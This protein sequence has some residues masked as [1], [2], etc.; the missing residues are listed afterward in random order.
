MTPQAD[1]AVSQQRSAKPLVP[2]ARCYSLAGM[3]RGVGRMRRRDFLGVLGGA[4]ATWPVAAHAQQAGRRPTVGFLGESTASDAS[5][6]AAAFQQRLRELGWI[7]RSSIAIE[8]RWAEGRRERFAEIAA[9]FVPIKVDVIVT[10][11][12]AVPALKEAT[13]VI[14]IIFTIDGDPVGRGLVASLARP[15]GNVTGLS[16]QQTELVGNWNRGCDRMFT[17]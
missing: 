16:G 14:P 9:E 4:A 6:R 7:E 15:G 8:Y 11:G 1:T 17:A 2:P 13:S 12:G 3:M 10:I 5:T